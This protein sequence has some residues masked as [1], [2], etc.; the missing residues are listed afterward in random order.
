MR[1]LMQDGILKI[2]QGQ[3]DFFQLRRVTAE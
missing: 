2:L 3:T 1:T